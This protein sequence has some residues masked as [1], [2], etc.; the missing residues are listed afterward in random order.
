[1]PAN[2]ATPPDR[3]GARWLERAPAGGVPSAQRI[4]AVAVLVALV[5]L[6]VLLRAIHHEARYTGGDPCANPNTPQVCEQQRKIDRQDEAE[7]L[8]SEGG[9]AHEME[10]AEAEVREGGAAGERS[11]NAEPEARER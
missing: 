10:N 5:L 9:A 7:N 3:D 8:A 6:F 11:Q 2:S 1:V 4:A